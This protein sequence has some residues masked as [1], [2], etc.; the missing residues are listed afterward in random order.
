ML[1]LSMGYVSHNQ[2][3]K[4]PEKI[5]KF[6]PIGQ[7]SID[8]LQLEQLLRRIGQPVRRCRR[9]GQLEWSPWGSET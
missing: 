1:D 8:V 5:L 3:V 4:R 9:H 7:G 6:F 2:R